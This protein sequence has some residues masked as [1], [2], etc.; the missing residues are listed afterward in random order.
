M[1]DKIFEFDFNFT[2]ENITNINLDVSKFYNQNTSLTRRIKFIKSILFIAL[3][4]G[5]VLN[6][7]Y[8]IKKQFN[9]SS[10]IAF[11]SIIFV[12]ILFKS[13]KRPIEYF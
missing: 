2:N 10:L 12:F 3:I 9:L 1:E 7:S 6:I 4:M 5:I 11:I 8:W 13:L